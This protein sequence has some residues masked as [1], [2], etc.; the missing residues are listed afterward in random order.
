MVGYDILSHVS[1][2]KV[3]KEIMRILDRIEKFN[4]IFVEQ[5]ILLSD[6]CVTFY[7]I[8]KNEEKLAQ[9]RNNFDKA[10]E[11]WCEEVEKTKV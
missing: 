2:I 4:L 5:D 9:V 8:Y 3:S 7:E 6:K 11:V 1:K 10:L